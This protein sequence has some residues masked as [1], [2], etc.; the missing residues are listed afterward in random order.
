MSSAVAFKKHGVRAI[1]S[2]WEGV[3]R[4]FYAN[5]SKSSFLIRK[6][7]GDELV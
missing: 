4:G 2:Q 7:E 5:R 1:P 6:G 3:G